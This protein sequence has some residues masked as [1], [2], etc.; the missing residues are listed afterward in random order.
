MT[1]GP[2]V[3]TGATGHVG[4]P[5][6]SLLIDAGVQVRAITRDPAG[7]GLPSAAEVTDSVEEALHGA[8]A[9][10]RNSRAL[11][12]RPGSGHRAGRG[13]GK[14]HPTSCAVGGQ[15]RRRPRASTVTLSR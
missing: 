10:F 7:T 5:L 9:V 14:C 3:V 13:R 6:V 4:R 11:R 2:I 12:R 1:S 15:R 8:S